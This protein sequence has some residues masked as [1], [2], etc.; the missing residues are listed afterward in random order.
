MRALFVLMGVLAVAG[1]EPGKTEAEGEVTEVGDTG[2]DPNAPPY[3]VIT[4]HEDGDEVPKG[5]SVTLSGVVGD[6]D[7]S[8]SELRVDWYVGDTVACAGAAVGSDGQTSCDIVFEAGASVVTL[9]VVDPEDA[10]GADQ[11]V[12]DVG[13]GGIDKNTPPECEITFPETGASG[14]LGDLALFM[15]LVSDEDEPDEGLAVGWSSDRDGGLGLSTPTRD[16]EVE[17]STAALS[18]GTH[19]ITLGVMDNVGAICTDQ[20]VYVVQTEPTTDNP[21]VVAIIEPEGGESF[22]EGEEID[23]EAITYDVEDDPSALTVVWTSDVDGVLS[24]DGPDSSG[25]ISFST[26]GLSEGI[27]V[28]TITVTD[29]DGNTSTDTVVI[30]ITANSPPTDP[31]VMIQPDPAQTDDGLTAVIITPATDPDGDPLT[32]LY[33]WYVDGVFYGTGTSDTVPS[34][35]TAKHQ[36]WRVEVVATDG[37]WESATAVDEITIDNTPP[38]IEDVDISPDSP[39]AEDTLSCTYSGFFDL[40]GDADH[41]T[42]AWYVNGSW[43]GSS[44][45]L[46]GAFGSGD[47]VTCTV[48]PHDGEEP[49]APVSDTIVIGNSAP[50]VLRA[51]LSPDPAYETSTM[52]CTP[53][54]VSDPDGDTGFSF[55]YRWEVDG[56]TLSGVSGST[57]GGTYFDKHQDIQCFI[58]ASDG[59]AWGAEADS[60]IVEVL[61]TPP[62]APE[63]MI[64]P[65][66]PEEA[67]VL[68]CIILTESTDVDGDSISY[69]FSWTVDGTAYSAASTTTWTGDTIPSAATA[70]GETWVCTVT[71]NDGETDGPSDSASVTIEDNCGPLGGEGEDGDI[72]VAAGT[73]TTLPLDAAAVVGDNPGGVPSLQVDDGSAFIPGD[74]V[75]V[76]TV[77]TAASTCGGTTAGYWEVHQIADLDGDTL[78][79]RADLGYSFNTSGGSVHQVVRV[80]AYGT[81]SLGTGGT[82]TAPAWDGRVGG[83]MIFR[84]RAVHLGASARIH[85]DGRGYFGAIAGDVPAGGPRGVLLDGGGTGG[86]GGAECTGAA[87]VGGSGVAGLGGAG[88]GGSAGGNDATVTG[89]TCGGGGSGWR[90]GV[91]GGGGGSGGDGGAGGTVM[92]VSELWSTGSELLDASADGGGGGTGGAGGAGRCTPSGTGAG[93][94]AGGG[95]GASWLGCGGGGGGAIAGDTGEEGEVYVFGSWHAT[96]SFAYTA[97]PVNIIEF[98]GGEECYLEL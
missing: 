22:R 84:S 29:S 97:D 8:L 48:T 46:S 16:G 94:S 78:Q 64:E 58:S 21:P 18:A 33:T 37:V 41:S 60:N 91:A 40:D 24:S 59:M 34:S 86:S 72:T 27:H 98:Y 77:S 2:C 10:Y 92:I 55:A 3:A 93:G 76:L 87:C 67:D 47:T 70:S 26:D 25:N 17:I 74:E 88:G 81:I 38:S 7:H 68:V 5:E 90:A 54:G 32:Y 45:S 75:L 20:V 73:T 4:S 15:G 65:A 31:E 11:V 12:L 43:A 79:L 61:N 82:L 83:I 49:G 30:T 28:I 71:P 95:A 36:V 14:D 19:I 9:V 66:F 57:L 13:G 80:P 56:V 63:I 69:D 51:L 85:M 23:F 44:A 50:T 62:T 42:F 52:V 96:A 6:S 53:D 89:G 39:S 1:C 35:A